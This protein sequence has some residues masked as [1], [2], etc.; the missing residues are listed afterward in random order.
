M[1]GKKTSVLAILQILEEYSDKDHILTIHD[2]ENYVYTKYNQKI[3][4]RTI[5]SNIN[6]L[7]DYEYDISTFKDN[8]VGYYLNERD[9][10]QS[11]ILLLCN[12]VHSSNFI[13]KN[14]S[15]EI[16]NKL[17]K[18]Q[19]K[20]FKREYHNEVFLDNLNK[21]E[22]QEFF[23]NIEIIQEAIHNKKSISFDYVQYDFNKKQV[24][25]KHDHK[26]TISPYSIIYFE[27]KTYLVGRSLT[28]NEMIH[29]RV[30][31]MI[32]VQIDET[33]EY[34][35]PKKIKDPYEYSKSKTLMFAGKKTKIT[36]K[37]KNY[38]LDTIIDDFGAKD[39]FVKQLDDNYFEAVVNATREGMKILALK[40]LADAEV[41][42]PIELRN[43]IKLII[44]D[45]RK[46]YK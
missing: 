1:N 39:T 36:L 33:L 4:R 34:L 21:V 7:I 24:K 40:Y 35:S 30:D 11:E 9:F 3:D 25:R 17:L 31:R 16:I 20:Y 28:Y 32:N 18:T 26:Y 15:N 5:Y 13:P 46:K 14:A 10:E 29:Y 43:E 27:G 42:S 8:G 45:A 37:C 38:L 44:D 2:I 41:T 6:M 19:G 23:L 12:A 22:N